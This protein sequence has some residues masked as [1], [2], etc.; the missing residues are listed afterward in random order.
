MEC[1]DNLV[2]MHSF[3]NAFNI[4]SQLENSVSKSKDE[5]QLELN[6]LKK[7]NQELQQGLDNLNQ[8][9]KALELVIAESN[10]RQ[11]QAEMA[12]MELE[13]I[14]LA[15]TDAIWVISDE[16]IV[17]RA[18]EAMLNLLGKP[19][20]EVLGK[21]CSE[22]LH[23]KLC[24]QESCPLKLNNGEQQQEYDIQIGRKNNQQEHY[25]L[26]SA[27]LTTIVGSAGIV[28]Q[29]KDITSRKQAEEKLTELNETLTKMA[30]VDGLTQIANR[31]HFDDTIEQE[32][33]RLARNKKPLSLLLADIDFFKKYNDHYGHQ[34]GDDC[35]RQVGKALAGMTL[36]S[37]DLVARYGGEEFILLLPETDLEGAICVGNQTLE[38]ISQ[39]GIKH[40]SSE[41][42]ETIT[43]SLGAATLVPS[44]DTSPKQL[45][46]LADQAL[47]QSKNTGR[48]RVTAA[49]PD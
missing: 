21:S 27:P 43:I 38:S 15:V 12:G 10:N 28:C 33:K 30:L 29:F 13:Q 5:T 20:D 17:A 49:H 18:N 16:G 42:A 1:W 40:T 37:A 14:F 23:N 7:E 24:S 26:S 41:V 36:R 22:L 9:Q 35:L 39:L 6:Q 2:D 25:I 3:D 45:I 31:R 47:Y 4:K 44:H 8:T 34:A 48:N 11:L 46:E 32:W 19:L